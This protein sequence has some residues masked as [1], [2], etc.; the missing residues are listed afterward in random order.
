MHI[1][2]RRLETLMEYDV[3]S[4]VHFSNV[5]FRGRLV[6]KLP[7]RSHRTQGPRI[8]LPEDTTGRREGEK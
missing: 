4:L 8:R 6:V 1:M 5:L 7:S 2:L 3:Q